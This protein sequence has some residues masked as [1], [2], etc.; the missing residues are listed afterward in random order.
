MTNCH[1]YRTSSPPPSI[2]QL[3]FVFLSQQRNVLEMRL[4]HLSTE[5]KFGLTQEQNN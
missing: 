5:A 3:N 1:F 4:P 2:A